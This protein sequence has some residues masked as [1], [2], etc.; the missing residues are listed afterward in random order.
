MGYPSNSEAEDAELDATVR[1]VVRFIPYAFFVSV[2]VGCGLAFLMSCSQ[3]KVAEQ[4]YRTEVL[5]CT[6]EAVARDAGRG[7]SEACQDAVD[8][9]WHI[10]VVNR[11][12]GAE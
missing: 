1:K 4:S 8:R 9:R 6:A 7:A 2:I 5:A 11:D 3:A 10:T 12:A